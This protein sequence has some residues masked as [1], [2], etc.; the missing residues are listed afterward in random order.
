[1]FRSI[2]TYFVAII[3]AV[4]TALS[5]GAP[6]V[7]AQS[8]QAKYANYIEHGN[9]GNSQAFQVKCA[10]DGSYKWLYLGQNSYQ[11]C[12]GG[13]SNGG[14]TNWYVP[15]NYTLCVRD[16]YNPNVGCQFA[17]SGGTWWSAPNGTWYAWTVHN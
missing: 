13:G 12:A 11:K 17:Y 6:S 5:I 3:L 9:V 16:Y 7:S 15:V 4:A 10:S 14:V 2:K 8:A 1:M